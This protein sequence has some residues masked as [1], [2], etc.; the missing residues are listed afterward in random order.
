MM[1][2]ACKPASCSGVLGRQVSGQR[3]ER[4][5]IAGIVGELDG[6]GFSVSFGHRAVQ[7]LDGLFCFVA[8]IEADEPDAFGKP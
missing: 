7:L 6:D 2:W 8:L 4:F 3:W 5:V 1:N